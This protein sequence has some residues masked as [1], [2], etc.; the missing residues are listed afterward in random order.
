VPNAGHVA[1][2]IAERILAL[3]N[4]VGRARDQ[5]GAEQRGEG[6]REAGDRLTL[7]RSLHRRF[8]F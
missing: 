7:H 5:R 8:R 4:R 6:N 3:E 2:E 1:L